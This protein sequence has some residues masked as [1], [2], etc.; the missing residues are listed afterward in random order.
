MDNGGHVQVRKE[1]LRLIKDT[2]LAENLKQGEYFV[3][4]V[5]FDDGTS[6]RIKV[7]S[8]EF[9]PYS[10]YAKKNQVVVNV[11]YDWTTHND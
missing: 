8:D 2:E 4:T 9:D 11:E 7:K 5:Y 3:W 6:K 10:Y 1:A